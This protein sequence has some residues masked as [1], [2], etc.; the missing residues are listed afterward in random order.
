MDSANSHKQIQITLSHINGSSAFFSFFYFLSKCFMVLIKP[1]DKYECTLAHNFCLVI[2][3]ASLVK[4][5]KVLW[6][7]EQE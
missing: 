6:L 5:K 7:A 2:V 3:Y 4:K 1:R